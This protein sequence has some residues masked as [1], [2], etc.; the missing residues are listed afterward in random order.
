MKKKLLADILLIL[1][2]LSA[3]LIL[4]ILWQG[5]EPGAHAVV[6]VDGRTVL[7]VPL[8]RDYVYTVT[9]GEWSSSIV[10]ENGTVRV[11]EADCPRQLCVKQGAIRNAGQVI[12]CLP[13]HLTVTVVSTA[14]DVDLVS[15]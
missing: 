8:D 1:A 4:R 13:H 3:A 2:V 11:A 5:G 7:Q 10:V 6:T 14:S 15:G 12:V 9:D